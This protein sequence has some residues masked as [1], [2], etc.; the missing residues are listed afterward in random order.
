M[1]DAAIYFLHIPKT[2]GTTLHAAIDTGFPPD[3]IC[4]AWLWDQLLML[5]APE[6]TRFAVY[7]GHFHGYLGAFL[8]RP[9]RTVTLLRDPV[10]RTISSYYYLL[11][12][13]THP[14]HALVRSLSLA[15][16]CAH[17]VTR[18]LM[19]NYQAAYLATTGAPRDPA[20]VLARTVPCR[21][22]EAPVQLALELTFT[23]FEPAALGSLAIHAL[24]SCVAVGVT[25]RVAESVALFNTV[26][27]TRIPLPTGSLNATPNRPTIA[28]LDAEIRKAI[29]ECTEVDRA[30]YA[31]AC[32]RFARD[33]RSLAA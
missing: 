5:P 28:E 25:E 33:A 3:A 12:H 17:P 13:P 16:V 26:L 21:A 30:L 18:H 11:R 15:D 27:G 19:W 9:L 24:D 32:E 4:P 2:G 10:E 22:V 23:D 14:L 31:C 29:W 8:G 1:D 7:R 20:A 6:R